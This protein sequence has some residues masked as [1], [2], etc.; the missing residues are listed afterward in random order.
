MVE[1]AQK[2]SALNNPWVQLVCG[3]ICMAMVANLQY[4]WPAFVK[5]LDGK[6]SW[7]TPAIQVAFTIFVV[8][9]TWLVPLEGWLVD[10]FGARMV[11]VGGGV[12][13]GLGWVLNAQVDSLNML[14]LAAALSGLGAGM[15]YGACVGNAI[16]WFPHHRGFAVGLTAAGYGAGSALTVGPIADMIKS[17][18]FEQAF[19]SFGLGQG[20]I[21]VLLGLALTQP[22]AALLQESPDIGGTPYNARPME[23]LREPTFWIMYAMFVLM[24]AGGLMATQ[25]LSPLAKDAGIVKSEV[26]V[27]GM[28]LPWALLTITGDFGGRVINGMTRP[29]LGWISD[30]YGREQT[31]C[32]AFCLCGLSIILLDTF[33]KDPFLFVLFALM[34]FL[35]WGEVYALFP[36]TCGDTFGTRHA[37]TNAGMLYTAKGTANLLVPFGPV[38]ISAT[39]GWTALMYTTA[40]MCIA[41]GIM[42]LW[43][44]KPMRTELVERYNALWASGRGR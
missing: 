6:F 44:L 5:P 9:Q 34:I 17:G 26:A 21:V 27:L 24:V 42:A 39:G 7:G 40:L 11:V 10:R 32:V 8:T 30:R 4:G 35:T 33:G 18:G 15:V 19:M 2:S 20:V 43:V 22:S 23:V 29:F 1:G 14:Y 37:A 36:A 25:Q 3:V 13:A 16:K 31:M 28:V 38:V 41:A 12:L